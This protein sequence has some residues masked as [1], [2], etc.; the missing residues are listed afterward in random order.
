MSLLS[1][2][3]VLRLR[4]SQLDLLKEEAKR[5]MPLEACALLLG[6]IDNGKARVEEVVLAENVDCSPYKFSISPEV[7][8]ETYE[9][10]DET[11][12]EVLGIFHSHPAPATPSDNDLKYMELNPC[13]WL[14]MSTIDWSVRAY[15]RWNREI[16][17]VLIDL[18]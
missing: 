1:R 3:E 15:Q 6:R 17:K 12:L 2:V 7:L 10:A 4:S 11:G 18:I 14:M 8:I 13:V 9:H 5:A 16:Q